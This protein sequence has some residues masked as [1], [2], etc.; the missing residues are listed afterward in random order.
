MESLCHFGN[1]DK[2]LSES[3]RILK[4]GGYLVCDLWLAKKRLSKK[5]F[6]KYLRPVCDTWILS[7]LESL[8]VYKKK[9]RALGFKICKSGEYS[10][11]QFFPNIIY[12]ENGLTHLRYQKKYFTIDKN[13]EF[14]MNQL[15][16]LISAYKSGCL[17]FGYLLAARTASGQR[18]LRPVCPET[19][20]RFGYS[21]AN[22]AICKGVA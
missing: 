7:S 10:E 4:K 9:L 8:T 5:L 17:K 13:Q 1:K 6:E 11:C 18:S 2:F 20:L 3:Y 14:F 12:L 15:E 21:L 22:L 16:S 19:T